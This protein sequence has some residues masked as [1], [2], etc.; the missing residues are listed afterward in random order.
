MGAGPKF[1]QFF[2]DAPVRF[3][4]LETH[5]AIAAADQESRQAVVILLRNRVEL[6]IV[7]TRA[8]DRESEKGFRHH[9]EAAVHPVALVLPNVQRPA[10][11][12]TEKPE[13]RA[14]DGFIRAVGREARLGQKVTGHVLGDELI[15]RHVRVE[16]AD[17]IVA[18]LVGVRNKRIELV[19]ARLGETHQVEPVPRPALAVLR[20]SEQAIHHL[21]ESLRRR[22][23]QKRPDLR[24]LRRQSNQIKIRAPQQRGLF[25]RR[26]GLEVLLLQFREQKAVDVHRR[27]ARVLHRR[28]FHG[29]RHRLPGPMCTPAFFEIERLLRGGDFR[30]GF[31]RPGRTVLHPRRE[32]RNLL[33][34]QPPFGRHLHILVGVMNRLDEQTFLGVARN[35]SGPG[36]TTLEHPFAGVQEQTALDFLAG[37]AVTFVT[38]LDEH[39][40]HARLEELQ[41]GRSE[42]SRENSPPRQQKTTAEKRHEI[43]FQR[44]KSVHHSGHH[45]GLVNHASSKAD[46]G[47]TAN[48]HKVL[49]LRSRQ[50]RL[51]AEQCEHRSHAGGGLLIIF[52]LLRLRV[53]FACR[54]PVATT[55][56]AGE[57]RLAKEP[58]RRAAPSHAAGAR[59]TR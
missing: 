6:V 39:R 38:A 29:G 21:R 15:V 35:E 47:G 23:V 57:C 40:P 28:R 10:H 32:I 31:L 52:L 9:V 53:C 59:S 54:R 51:W 5:L 24:R 19:S 48:L 43:P 36:V 37:R 20:R 4:R 41:V 2:G 14:E 56:P 27:P 8:G 33:R 22:V 46:G 12:F 13:T 42:F 55:R 16:G 44:R 50:D 25:R 34:R 49:T 17:D 18:V 3:N 1:L 11:L 26:R 30:R 7:A 45:S 58:R